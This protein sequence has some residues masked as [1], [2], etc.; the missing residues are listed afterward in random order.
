MNIDD[1]VRT[2]WSPI[3]YFV[4]G[5]VH[6]REVAA[7]L[8]QDCFWKACKGWEQFRGESTVYTW[9]RH[10]ALN[11]I[12]TFARNQRIQFWCRVPLHD[13]STIEDLL[14]HPQAS[15]E[16]TLISSERLQKVWRAAG[17]LPSRQQR[18][19]VLRFGE[20]MEVNEIARAMNISETAVKV[21]LFR[22]VQFLRKKVNKPQIERI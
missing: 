7:D 18:A 22:A 20:E 5:W 1:V 19:F 13:L 15:A 2:H 6:D 3:F 9:L 21:H 10:I 14:P 11:T 4:L 12:H 17:L 8:T 16:S